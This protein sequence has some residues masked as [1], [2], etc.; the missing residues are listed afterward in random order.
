MSNVFRRIV[1]PNAI[2][3]Q[4]RGGRRIAPG[5][6]VDRH[7]GAHFSIPEL[8]EVLNVADTPENRERCMR[9]VEEILRPKG[10]RPTADGV[11]ARIVALICQHYNGT[12]EGQS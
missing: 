11:D 5:V 3:E 1:G 4:L 12:R 9:L 10:Y 6:W 2:K 8:L 7:G